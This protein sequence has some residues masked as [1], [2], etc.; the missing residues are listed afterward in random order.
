MSTKFKESK[1][2]K[3]LFLFVIGIIS[4]LLVWGVSGFKSEFMLVDDNRNQWEPIINT[5]YEHYIETGEM[6]IYNFYQAKGLEIADE[7]YYGIYNPIMFAAYLLHHYVLRMDCFSTITFYIFF[8][9]MAGSIA[10]YLLCRK[11][12]LTISQSLFVVFMYLGCS[13]FIRYGHWYYVFH[14]FW[15]IP[16]LLYVFLKT[17]KSK[18][19]SYVSCGIIL[20]F[21]ILLGNVQYTVYQYMLYGILMLV[22]AIAVDWKYLYKMLSNCLLGIVVSVPYLILMLQSTQRSSSFSGTSEFMKNALTVRGSL[23]FSVLPDSILQVINPTLSE[24]LGTILDVNTMGED[25]SSVVYLGGLAICMFALF[26]MA[27]VWLIRYYRNNKDKLEKQMTVKLL[28]GKVCTVVKG[29]LQKDTD[30]HFYHSFKLGILI[31]ILFFYSFMTSGWIALIL[32]QVPVINGFRYLF[33]SIF[34][35]VPLLLVMA[36]YLLQRI[37]G[38]KQERMIIVLCTIF[39]LL[40][41]VNNYFIFNHYHMTRY[42][43]M[44]EETLPQEALQIRD[45]I[46]TTGIDTKNYRICSFLVSRDESKEPKER[47][48]LV[49]QSSF[50]VKNKIIR[51]IGTMAEVCTLN[52]YEM[53]I[54]ELS[55][56]QSDCFQ[57]DNWYVRYANADSA[58]VI[59]SYLQDQNKELLKQINDNAVKYYFFT[60]ESEELHEFERLI[61]AYPGLSIERE[62]PFLEHTTVVELSNV[63]SLCTQGETAI[64]PVI[65]YDEIFIPVADTDDSYRLSFTY[66]DRLKAEWINADSVEEATGR[67]IEKQEVEVLQ[68]KDGYVSIKNTTNQAGMIRLYYSNPLCKVVKYVS[69]VLTILFLLIMILSFCSQTGRREK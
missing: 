30:E 52:A 27:A 3:C 43:I 62:F 37:A 17:R 49:M 64:E 46:E 14:N 24:T 44:I 41:F 34:I 9:I 32:H 12:S 13:T 1:L 22:M 6:P 8:M 23:I 60:A 26:V 57:K 15:L 69:V 11:L 38:K 31:V 47:E 54:S 7:G 18:Y 42:S 50:D 4:V 40:G 68:D 29:K 28:I 21:S 63:Q 48:E 56:K 55:I 16:L 67:D 2:A 66:K 61:E 20:G 58:D 10:A 35:I 53:T 25:E 5:A 45:A 36:A 33:K 65:R 59:F 51:N 19:L 39:T